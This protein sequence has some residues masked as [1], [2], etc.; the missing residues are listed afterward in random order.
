MTTTY[1]CRFTVAELVRD[2]KDPKVAA[3]AEPWDRVPEGF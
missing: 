3:T 1:I 2:S